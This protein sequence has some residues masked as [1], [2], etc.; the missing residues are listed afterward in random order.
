ML[1][2]SYICLLLGNF[3]I[4]AYGRL[5]ACEGN[6]LDKTDETDRRGTIEKR[7]RKRVFVANVTYREAQQIFQ[8]C[9]ATTINYIMCEGNW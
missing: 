8:F 2:L 5:T 6:G 4:S 3:S 1:F 7:K 9:Y